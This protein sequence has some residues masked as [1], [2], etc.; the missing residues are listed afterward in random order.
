MGVDFKIGLDICVLNEDTRISHY[1]TIMKSLMFPAAVDTVDLF[2]YV[3][4]KPNA[5]QR[6]TTDLTQSILGISTQGVSSKNQFSLSF[7]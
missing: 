1:A 5:W 3:C 6:C 7:N 4:Q 2:C